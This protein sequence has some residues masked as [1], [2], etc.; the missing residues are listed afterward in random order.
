MKPFA[1]VTVDL[2]GLDCYRTI[3]GRPLRWED[4][5]DPAYTVGVRRLL[6][7]LADRDIN[8]TLFVIG[9]DVEKHAQSALLRS[10]TALG[11]ELA[12]HSYSHD[13]ALRDLSRAAIA[14]DLDRADQALADLGVDNVGFRTPGYNVDRKIIDICNERGYLY[15]SSVFACPPYWLAKAAVMGWMRVSGRTS[16]SSMTRI[17]TLAAPVTPYRTSRDSF[18]KRGDG[19]WEVP[20]CVVPGV[21]FPVIGTSL[22]VMKERGFDLAYPVIRQTYRQ[23]LNLEFHAIDFMDSHDPGTVD[24]VDVQPDLR[25]PWAQKRTLYEHVFDRLGEDYQ[26]GTMR[27]AVEDLDAS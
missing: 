6:D 20:M 1:C 12:S 22:H 18:W 26:F 9:R 14:L 11:H 4:E 8:A 21:R 15:D 3:H 7:L 16:G 23:L 13:Y 5:P 24:L 2:D 27:E 10:A 25:V 17:E 19:I